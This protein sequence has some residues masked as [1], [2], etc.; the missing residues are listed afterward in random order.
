MPLSA[1]HLTWSYASVST[2]FAARNGTLSKSWGAKG[3]KVPEL[4]QSN[5]GPVVEA[6]FNVVAETVFGGVLLCSVWILVADVFVQKTY[7]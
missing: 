4:C 1:V 7:T 3:L 6:T 2:A 5:S